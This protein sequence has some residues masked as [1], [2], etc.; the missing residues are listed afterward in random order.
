MFVEPSV[1]HFAVGR[2]VQA[3]DVEC[4]RSH[5]GMISFL[6]PTHPGICS[7]VTM[8]NATLPP[9]K[10]LFN[11]SWRMVPLNSHEGSGPVFVVIVVVVFKS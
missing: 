11:S 9:S 3:S 4:H 7:T 1:A 10:G 8:A 5:N 2:M 6:R